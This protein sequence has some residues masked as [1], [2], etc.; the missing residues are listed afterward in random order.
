MSK[1]TVISV[2]ML[3]IIVSLTLLLTLSLIVYSQEVPTPTTYIP[4][5]VTIPSPSSPS[6]IP[7]KVYDVYGRVRSE[8]YLG[9]TIYVV[10][11]LK[12]FTGSTTVDITLRTPY[13]TYYWSGVLSGGYNYALRFDIVE[14]ICEGCTYT[15]TIHACDAYNCGSG[16]T[17]WVERDHPRAEIL[18]VS[19][20]DEE[21]RNVNTIIIDRTYRLRVAIKNTGEIGYSYKVVVKSGA[22][23]YSASYVVT[24]DSKDTVTL[25][26]KVTFKEVPKGYVDTIDVYV[27]GRG[28][29]DD[30]RSITVNVI[31]PR[32]GPFILIS[33]T[34]TDNLKEE[35]INTLTVR[36]KN[37]GWSGRIVSIIPRPNFDAHVDVSIDKYSFG[38]N[39]EVLITMRIIPHEGGRRNIRLQLTYVSEYTG[40]EYTDEF[41]I[42]VIIYVKLKV[43]A[44][45]TDGSPIDVC[46]KL[47]TE[48]ISERWL[49]PGTYEIKVPSEVKI[50]SDVKYI[51]S[52]WSDGVTTASREL[53]LEHSTELK[54]YFEEMYLVVI[55]DKI[56]GAEREEWYRKGQILHLSVPEYRSAGPDVRWRFDRWTGDCYSTLT[57][58]TITVNKPI[59]CEAKWVKQYLVAVYNVI[60]SSRE[61]VFSEWV[62]EGRRFSIDAYTYKPSG[63]VGF[64]VRVLFDKWVMN[65][66]EYRSEY[67]SFTVKEPTEVELYW[68]KDYTGSIGLGLGLGVLS[69]G[70]VFRDRIRSATTVIMQRFT[71]VRKEEITKPEKPPVGTQVY[72]E[73]KEE[74]LPVREFEEKPYAE[75]TKVKEE[76]KEKT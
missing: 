54:A 53:K 67:V 24:I 41:D 10:F 52:K 35:T 56:G 51:F 29:L 76:E 70:Y 65:G 40:K 28:K 9:E 39:D 69:I 44:V 8:V 55:E 13:G 45:L 19:I 5:T 71:R 31:P 43:E 36:L 64:L 61:E 47:G 32:P 17:S 34:G 42:P 23:L 46:I 26:F 37:T 14:P 16:S 6:Q 50:S 62:D 25:E 4:V 74:E 58:I 48:C 22:G 66:K 57:T 63:E 12:Q 68:Y 11:S 27:Y 33:T 18:D 75:G 72:A 1:G 20:I 2:V 21:G 7:V 38:P 59:K 30:S 3:A 15:L 49:L 60:D 73:K